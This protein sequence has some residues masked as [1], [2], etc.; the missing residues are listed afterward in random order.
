MMLR[1]F[2]WVQR[3]IATN[4]SANRDGHNIRREEQSR[5]RKAVAIPSGLS[6]PSSDCDNVAKG[7]EAWVFASNRREFSMWLSIFWLINRRNGNCVTGC[8]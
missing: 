1:S 2:P 7:L 8:N 6:K 5:N 3:L 4:G